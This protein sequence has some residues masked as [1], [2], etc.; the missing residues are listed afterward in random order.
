MKRLSRLALIFALLAWNVGVAAVPA[1]AAAAAIALSPDTGPVG[2]SVT[3]TG[4]GFPKKSPGTVRAGTS[5]AAFTVSASGSF[6]AK[7]VIT[8]TSAPVLPVQAAAGTAEASAGFT[9][10]RS[11]SSTAPQPAPGVRAAALRFGVGTPGG[12]LASAELDAV[13]SLVGEAPSV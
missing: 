6:T 2:T 10:T 8:E 4:T 3:I 9:V 13:A 5:S 12:P 7:V 1:R 11:A